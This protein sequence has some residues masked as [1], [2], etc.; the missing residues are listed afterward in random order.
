MELVELV[1]GK[2]WGIFVNEVGWSV[3]IIVK[4]IG[5]GIEKWEG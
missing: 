4:K 3:I 5:K 2:F 1:A